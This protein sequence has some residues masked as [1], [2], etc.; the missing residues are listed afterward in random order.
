MS[1][2]KDHNHK[3]TSSLKSSQFG[4]EVKAI[5]EAVEPNPINEIWPDSIYSLGN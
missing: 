2:R 4:Q 5:K 3:N 1:R